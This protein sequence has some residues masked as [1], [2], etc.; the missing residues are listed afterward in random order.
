MVLQLPVVVLLLTAVVVLMRSSGLRLA[1]ALACGLL[2]FFLAGSRAG[3]GTGRFL[4]SLVD[5]LEG[6][7]L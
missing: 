2:G 7:H 3:P 4:K 6:L 1:H 5:A